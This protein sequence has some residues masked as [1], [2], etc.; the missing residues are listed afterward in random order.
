MA[1]PRADG[2]S[3][4]NYYS[5]CI[6]CL[7]LYIVIVFVGLICLCFLFLTLDQE[8]VDAALLYPLF[9]CIYAHSLIAAD[10]AGMIY[11]CQ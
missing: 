8:Y 4:H 11:I 3:L 5:P 6:D 2:N 10:Q 1:V 9:H 7:V